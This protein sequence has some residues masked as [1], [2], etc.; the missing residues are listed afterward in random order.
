MDF[1]ELSCGRA[2]V[3]EDNVPTSQA[4]RLELEVRFPGVIVDIA[5]TVADAMMLLESSLTSEATYHLAVIDFKL[6]PNKL[7][8]HPESD[9]SIARQFSI[10]SPETILV[11]VTAYADDPEIKSYLKHQTEMNEAGRLFVPKQGDWVKE[12]LD[13]VIRSIHNRRV[14]QRFNSLFQRRTNPGVQRNNM[15]Q[16][17]IGRS[18]RARSLAVAQLCADASKYWQYLSE[19]LHHDLDESLGH[20]SDGEHHYVGVARRPL[21]ERTRKGRSSE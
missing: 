19:S 10:R 7:G 16:W 2:L 20:S 4:I 8:E 15:R 12:M 11:H 1:T 6:P 13:Q 9:F 17:S 3:V 21:D 5:H 18:D 14:R